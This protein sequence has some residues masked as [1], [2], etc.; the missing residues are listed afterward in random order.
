LPAGAVIGDLETVCD[1]QMPAKR[2][3]AKPALEADDV[4]LLHRA[5]DRRCR[6]GWLLH[7]WGTPETGK[8]AMHPDN[9]SCELV[10]LDLMMPQVATD[11]AG[12][13]IV[14]TPERKCISGPE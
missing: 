13:L 5:S 4:V 9:Q 11:D 3:C 12:D 8:R 14:S 1:P 2:L 6:L 7:R 10:G